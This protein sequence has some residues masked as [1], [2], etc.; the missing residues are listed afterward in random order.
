[1][2]AHRGSVSARPLH[3]RVGMKRSVWGYACRGLTLSIRR[4]GCNSQRLHF[5]P[6]RRRGKKCPERPRAQP[7]GVEGLPQTPRPTFWTNCLVRTTVDEKAICKRFHD[8]RAP[9]N[10][11]EALPTDPVCACNKAQSPQGQSTRQLSFLLW[12]SACS[13]EAG[14]SQ[15]GQKFKKKVVKFISATMERQQIYPDLNELTHWSY[16]YR[17]PAEILQKLEFW[18]GRSR[19]SRFFNDPKLK[20]LHEVW[21]MVYAGM[22]HR[23]LE[24]MEADVCVVE[25]QGTWVDGQVRTASRVT[26]YQIAIVNQRPDR[27][28]GREYRELAALPDDK[29]VKTPYR[30]LSI[31]EVNQRVR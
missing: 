13:D 18:R 19:L 9:C 23:L 7:E 10:Q 17:Q 5:F 22:A 1:M 26:E 14:N 12:L 16:E 20:K 3:R 25:E 21:V 15:V 11:G 28:V 27:A 29:P 4:P 30:P 31:E 2:R 24:N 8:E 6:R